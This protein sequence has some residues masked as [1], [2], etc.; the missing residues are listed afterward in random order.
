MNKCK[1]IKKSD[2]EQIYIKSERGQQLDMAQVHAVNSGTIPGLLRIYVEQRTFS[3]RLVYDIS[4]FVSLKNFLSEPLNK[5]SFVRILSSILQTL[6]SMQELHFSQEC[7]LMD[8]D[9]VMVIP[10]TQEICFVYVPIQE[11]ESGGTLRDF[12]LNIIQFGSFSPGEDNG[13]IKE[14]IKLL[15]SSTDFSVFKLEQLMRRLHNSG[16]TDSTCPFCGNR[17]TLESRF[18]NYCGCNLI[19][20]YQSNT[21]KDSSIPQDDDEWTTVLDEEPDDAT[22]VLEDE[23]DDGTTVLGSGSLYQP[24]FPYLIRKKNEEKIVIDKPVFRLGKEKQYCD[25][26]ISDNTTVSRSHADIITRGDRY[27]ILDQK[28]TNGTF[29]DG[30]SIPYK[31][32]VELFSGTEIRLSN[33]EFTFYI[34]GAQ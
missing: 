15:N 31:Q 21:N 8:F 16:K 20:A 17:V 26:F 12:L 14:Y 18:C 6:Q 1:V 24:T 4:G 27:F 30:R 11:Y 25:Y 7:L 19:Q 22:T 10:S 28:S 2:L 13:Y 29:I 5:T 34:E 32:E 23:L 3:F 9:K 33:E